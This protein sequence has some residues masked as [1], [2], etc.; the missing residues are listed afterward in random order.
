MTLRIA[1]IFPDGAMFKI[2]F[3]SNECEGMKN[4]SKIDNICRFLAEVDDNF[5]VPDWG[6]HP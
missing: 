6:W 5:D 3:K 4:L 1:C 2:W